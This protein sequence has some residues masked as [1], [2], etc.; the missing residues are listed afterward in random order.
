M[1]ISGESERMI[2]FTKNLQRVLRR[3]RTDEKNNTL[4]SYKITVYLGKKET[5]LSPSDTLMILCMKKK[6][7]SAF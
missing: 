1:N 2:N 5:V 3:L 4:I 6:K 7:L